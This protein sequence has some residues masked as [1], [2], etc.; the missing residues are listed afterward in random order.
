MTQPL[1]PTPDDAEAAAGDSS[2]LGGAG[3]PVLDVDDVTK[4]YPGE[5]PV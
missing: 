3:L 4:R 5:P 2:T 1:P